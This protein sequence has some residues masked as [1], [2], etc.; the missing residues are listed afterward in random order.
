MTAEN[1][2]Y[3]QLTHLLGVPRNNSKN[4]QGT[5]IVVFGI[6]IDISCFTAQIPK[7]KLE[8]ATRATAK[9]LG[10]KSVSFIDM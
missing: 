4:A 5:A 8:K 9:V 3:V 10:R 6:E 1:K 2:A 7:E